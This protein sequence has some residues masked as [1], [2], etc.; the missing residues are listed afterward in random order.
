MS[1]PPRL[2]NIP[3]RSSTEHYLH[4]QVQLLY[5]GLPL[6]LI[7]SLIIALLLSISHLTVVG[8]AEIIYWNFIL[9]TTLIARLVLWQFWLN[10]DQLYSRKCW[11]TLFRIGAWIGGAAWGSAAILIFATN[12][13][14]YQALLS[15]SLAGVVSGSLTSLSSDRISAIGF[16]LLAICPLSIRII[17]EDSPTAFAMSTMTVLFIYFVLSSSGRA[18]KELRRKTQQNENLISLSNELQKNREVDAIVTKVQGQFI[19]DKNYLDAMNTIITNTL[20]LSRSEMGFIGEICKDDND[21]P[22]MKMVVCS[23]PDKDPKYNFFRDQFKSEKPEFRNLNGIFGNIISTG[24]PTFCGNPRHDIRSIGMPDDHPNISNLVGIPVFHSN[25]LVAI[26]VLA[27]SADNYDANTLE[28]FLPITNLIGQFIHTIHLQKQHKKDIADL[29]ETSLQTQTILD[30]IADGVISIDKYGTIKSF[31]KAAETIFGYEGDQIIDGNIEQLM[32]GYYNPENTGKTSDRSLT[33]RKNI[34]GIGREITGVRRNGKYFPIDL[35]VS[36]IVRDSEPMFIGIIRDIS[37]KKSMQ[38]NYT[39]TLNN[40]AKGLHVSIHAISLS[41][42][43]LETNSV[44]NKNTSNNNLIISAKEEVQKLQDQLLSIIST[45]N[46]NNSEK[47]ISVHAAEQINN[48]VGSYRHVAELRG[49][50][51]ILSNRIYDEKILIIESMFADAMVFFLDIAAENSP[52]FS[53]I[54]IFIEQRKGKIRIYFIDKNDIENQDQ[55]SQDWKKWRLQL[56]KMHATSGIE[57]VYKENSNNEI[58]IIYMEFPLSMLK[59]GY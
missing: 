8:Q 56:R 53:E 27:N 29:E 39:S 32:P 9:G 22:F 1:E 11:L 15:F 55:K 43:I 40:L 13:A 36:R 42:N 21:T 6:S 48:Y 38:E 33:E 49:S 46:L 57:K 24:K 10:V 50:R 59:A 20:E 2:V 28:L 30:D 14:V 7:S 34:V 37:E 54:K 19:S 51:F 35:M 12:D 23:Y 52:P 16:A 17:V 44:A 47:Y 45:N 5:K 41:L 3:S 18:Q 31:N 25:E 58:S 26:L 4:E